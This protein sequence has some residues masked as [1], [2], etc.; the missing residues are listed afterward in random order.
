MDFA[1]KK[2]EG[3]TGLRE[4]GSGAGEFLCSVLR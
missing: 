2:D 4:S 1:L 3:E